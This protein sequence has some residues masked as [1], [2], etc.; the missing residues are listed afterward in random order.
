MN[1]VGRLRI[2]ELS[3]RV[4]VSPEL[5]RAWETRYA[6]VRPERTAGG[7]RLYSEED[8]RRVRLM[9]DQLAGG[10]SA[11]EAARHA[12]LGD[13]LPGLT[14]LSLLARS[15]EEAFDALDEPEA[16]AVLDRL[17]G[18]F[19]LA[20]ALEEVIIPFLRRVG[21]RWAS[22]ELTVASEHFT[23]NV[24][25]GRLRGLAR[26]WGQGI[27]PRAMLACAPGEQHDLGLLCFGLLLRERGWRITYLGAA[28]PSEDISATLPGLTPA[29]VVLSA[30]TPQRFEEAAREIQ[31]LARRARVAIGGAG[32]SEA[33]ADA[34]GAELLPA[35]IAEG[36]AALSP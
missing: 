24:I 25:G 5:L 4:G 35:G 6:V 21:E 28:T 8:E 32:A 1:G 9:K 34:L 17:F 15:L 14:D 12:K 11:S 7:L 10:L 18:S 2:G 29:V 31:E 33:A 16:Q 22:A 30:V 13:V 36:A 20:S 23:S 27:G 19:A 26:G 3:R